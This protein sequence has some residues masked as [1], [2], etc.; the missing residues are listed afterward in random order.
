MGN[1]LNKEASHI[2]GAL[3]DNP[4]TTDIDYVKE[5]LKQFSDDIPSVQAARV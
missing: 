1:Y 2:S 4:G 5:L 3:L